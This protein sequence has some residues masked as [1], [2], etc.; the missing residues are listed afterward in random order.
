MRIAFGREEDFEKQ[1]NT[2]DDYSNAVV[3]Y[4]TRW[5]EML[6][7]AILDKWPDF[8]WEDDWR[9]KNYISNPVRFAE[10]FQPNSL[11]HEADTE[12]VTGFMYGAAAWAIGEYWIF[13]KHF[14]LW[15]N[16]YEG[17]IEQGIKVTEKNDSI[18]PAVLVIS[19]E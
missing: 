3:E 13:G 6:E 16:I 11:G 18:N 8:N 5:A 2:G 15:F 7:K 9:I 4:G 17:G 14:R 1:V 10:L 12:G 19:T